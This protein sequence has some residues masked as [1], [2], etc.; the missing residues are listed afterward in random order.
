P[1]SSAAPGGRGSRATPSWPALRPARVRLRAGS[2]PVST[3]RPAA[4][5]P[6]TPSPR[7]VD[8]F[9]PPPLPGPLVDL[10]LDAVRADLLGLRE[11]QLQS[12]DPVREEVLAAPE[13]RG[14]DHQPEL[15]DQVRLQQRTHQG[16][17]ARDQADA[18]A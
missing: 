11:P 7:W 17:A 4:R 16:A 18:V 6:S 15:V 8:P 5:V 13:H 3:P 1:P 14:K 9:S 10:D 12:V 2:P